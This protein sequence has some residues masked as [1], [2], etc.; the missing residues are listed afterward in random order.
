MVVLP[1][2]SSTR[3]PEGMN[4]E[5]SSARGSIFVFCAGV[6]GARSGGSSRARLLLTC[7]FMGTRAEVAMPDPAHAGESTSP[8][9]SSPRFEVN[10]SLLLPSAPKRRLRLLQDAAK[11]HSPDL[12]RKTRHVVGLNGKGTQCCRA[13]GRL[14]FRARQFAQES[15]ERFVLVHADDGVVIASHAD[16][17]HKGRAIRQ[18]PVIGCRR[19]RVRT[20]HKAH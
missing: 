19:M 14:E 10:S 7:R 16:I 9:E 11:P 1:L 6:S 2:R 5:A 12:A 8:T 20:H 13:S 4:W 17:R 18:D 3:A 15:I